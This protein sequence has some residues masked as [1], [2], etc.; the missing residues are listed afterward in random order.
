M[1]PKITKTKP[2]SKKRWESLNFSQQKVNG[3]DLEQYQKSRILLIG[4]GAI[5]S[6]VALGVVRKGPGAITVMDDDRVELKNLTRQ[7]FSAKDIGKNK[8]VQLAKSLSKQGFFRT[9]VTGY[10]YRFQEAVELSLDFSEYDAVICGVD[11]NP[12]RVAVTKYCLEKNIP[13]V[14]GAVSR[15]GNQMY[16][17]IQKLGKACFGCIMPNAINDDSYPCNLPGIIDI[18]QV[19]AG[20]IVYALDTILMNRHCEWNL[21]MIALDGSVPDLSI[22]KH[23]DFECALCKQ[24]Q[25][26]ES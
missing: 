18:N 10:P 9:D 19:V 21:R 3:F 14:M 2:I 24:Y 25:R 20:I 6:N 8:A 23:K 11:N 4:A 26:G 12:T 7:L 16:C 22:N 13:L 1:K 15:D 5:G 17:A